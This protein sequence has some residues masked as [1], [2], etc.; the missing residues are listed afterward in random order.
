M[1]K[2]SFVL[3][4]MLGSVSAHAACVTSDL[5]GTWHTFVTT[6]VYNADLN[7]DGKPDAAEVTIPY[8]C[9]VVVSSSGKITVASSWC[10]TPNGNAIKIVGGTLKINAAC[11]ISGTDVEGDPTLGQLSREKSTANGVARTTDNSQWKAW[12]AVKQ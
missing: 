12:A 9:K 10:K 1:K 4:M 8:R 3:T 11:N 7:G 2:M 6:A 5:A